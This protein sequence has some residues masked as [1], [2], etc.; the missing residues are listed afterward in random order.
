MEYYTIGYRKIP[1]NGTYSIQ[2]SFLSLFNSKINLQTRLFL[3][4][5]VK[6][7]YTCCF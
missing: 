3:K 5:H 2:V 7:R 1:E 6:I 4:I